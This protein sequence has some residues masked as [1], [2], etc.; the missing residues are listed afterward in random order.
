M[1]DAYI[2][3][4]DGENDSVATDA[5]ACEIQPTWNA[6]VCPG[7]VGRLYFRPGQIQ[8][9]PAPG[10]LRGGFGFGF[11]R[12]TPPP[13]GTVRPAPAAPPAPPA[14]ITVV[15]NG[16]EHKITAN[17][18]TVRA[19]TEFQVITER[20]EVSLSLAEMDRGS[21]ILVEVPGFA[22]ANAG[23]EQG[24]LAALRQANE[25]SWFRGDD[26]LWVKLV[27]AEPL[28]TPVKPSNTQ[29]SITLSR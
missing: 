12:P 23:A 27:V 1:G 11:Q 28:L 15:R 24:S 13:P 2:L 9:L 16:K 4:H 21:W 25:T 29:A 5:E 17:Q 7:D 6:S 18:S 26:A 14:P 8:S 3:I 19:G 20:P 10:E 22:S